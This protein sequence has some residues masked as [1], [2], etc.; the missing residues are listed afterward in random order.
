MTGIP[1]NT[2]AA[3]SLHPSPIFHQTSFIP[4]THSSSK[5][6]LTPNSRSQLI[7]YLR[8]PNKKISAMFGMGGSEFFLVLLVFLMFFGSNKIPEIARGLG[9]GIRQFKDAANGIQEEIEK[10]ANSLK[11][12]MEVDKDPENTES[13]HI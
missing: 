9:K 4:F 1:V 3:G 8:V 13:E 2:T 5:F 6:L 11:K 12:E 7:P 10:G